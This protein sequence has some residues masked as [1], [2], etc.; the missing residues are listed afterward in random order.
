MKCL[1]DKE[2]GG[3]GE[4]DFGQECHVDNMNEEGRG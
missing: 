4:G 1:K 2:V 3:G